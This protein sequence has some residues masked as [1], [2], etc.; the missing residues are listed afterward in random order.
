M[1]ES[2][3]HGCSFWGG[4]RQDRTLGEV[5]VWLP[6]RI[7]EADLAVPSRLVAEM[8]QALRAVARL[9]DSHGQH[10]G[11]LST[12]LLRAE[13]V[14]SSK[15]EHIQASIEDYARAL[16]G[17]KGNTSA[18]SMVASTRA[19]DDLIGSVRGGR[20][21]TLSN[22]L[23][24]HRV[25]MQDDVHE[26]SYAAE[27]RDMQNWIGGFLPAR[28]PIRPTSGDRQR[29]P[30]GPAPVRQSGQHERADAGCGHTCPVRIHPSLHRR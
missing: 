21:L 11:S 10:L 25:L 7:G 9:D 14:A 23:D 29:L 8:D 20:E 16:H 12:L 24:A 28:G 27:V 26:R 6:P 18:V 1:D 5:E 15:I 2:S 13:S 3:G 17:I 30:D 22:V 4:T 19:L